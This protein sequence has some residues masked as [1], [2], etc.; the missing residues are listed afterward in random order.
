MLLI[1]SPD[2][3]EKDQFGWDHDC[4]PLSLHSV[5]IPV[6]VSILHKKYSFIHPSLTLKAEAEHGGLL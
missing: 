5:L 2:M 1:F 3:L 4:L 6:S